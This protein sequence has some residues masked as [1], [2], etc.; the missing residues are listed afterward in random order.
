MLKY[1]RAEKFVE[2]LVQTAREYMSGLQAEGCTKG[3]AELKAAFAGKALHFE[4]VEQATAEPV[5]A[6]LLV[7]EGLGEVF[8][9]AYRYVL[10]QA[11][12]AMQ[13]IHEPEK[14]AVRL[15]EMLREVLVGS[16]V[17]TPEMR[18]HQERPA[19]ALQV[20]SLD[21]VTGNVNLK[22]FYVRVSDDGQIAYVE[23]F[24]EGEYVDLFELREYKPSRV[25]AAAKKK[26]EEEGVEEL[27]T[28]RKYLFSVGRT[29]KLFGDSPSELLNGCIRAEGGGPKVFPIF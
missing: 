1:F 15:K 19:F 14:V 29:K 28:G 8:D 5:P 11:W 9:E 18:R 23:G 26:E 2:K 7:S 20:V 3:L 24:E 22:D 12:A 25:H 10:T 4:D 27:Q 16:M 13:P 17:F 6:E 21:K